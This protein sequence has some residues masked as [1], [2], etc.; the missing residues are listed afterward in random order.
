[1]VAVR[2]VYVSGLQ[3]SGF[4]AGL[5]QPFGLGWYVSGLRPLRWCGE[6]GLWL[7]RG[8]VWGIEIRPRTGAKGAGG[9]GVGG[10]GGG[11][12]GGLGGG[13]GVWRLEPTHVRC[14]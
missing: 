11:G 7:R 9:G 12:G 3:P 14:A 1:M 10:G 5:T 4:V 2:G 8:G 13:G 6:C